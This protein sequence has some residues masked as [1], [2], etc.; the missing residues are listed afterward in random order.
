MIFVII[1]GYSLPAGMGIYWIFGAVI[2][3]VQSIIMELIQTRNRHKLALQNNAESELSA[4]R[5]SK[6]HKEKAE[7]KKKSDKPLWRK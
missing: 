7:K 5:R 6:H 2:A 1:M 3:I 4:I